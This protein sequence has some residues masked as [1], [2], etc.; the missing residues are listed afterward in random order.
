MDNLVM[1][2]QKQLEERRARGGQGG[3]FGDAHGDGQS[4]PGGGRGGGHDG[5]SEPMATIQRGGNP[6]QATERLSKMLSDLVA[7]VEKRAKV[8]V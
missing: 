8:G 3:G 7:Q 1:E 6:F 5:G 4:R 2:R